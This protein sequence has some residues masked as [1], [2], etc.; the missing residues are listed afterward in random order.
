M[1][2]RL[3]TRS[4]S[5]RK[6][7]APGPKLDLLRT[8]I[9]CTPWNKAQA[10]IA[11]RQAAHHTPCDVEPTCN[12]GKF[13]AIVICP[14]SAHFETIKDSFYGNLDRARQRGQVTMKGRRR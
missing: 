8:R 11:A 14:G 3:F 2:R 5:L 6:Y 9:P 4:K 13:T 7:A 12:E 10:M 1:A